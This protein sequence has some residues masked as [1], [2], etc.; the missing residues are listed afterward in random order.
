MGPSNSVPFEQDKQNRQDDTW[1]ERHT[2]QLTQTP[3]LE[4]GCGEGRDSQ[5]LFSHGVDVI[6]AD[7]AA[8]ALKAH[9]TR[10]PNVPRVRLDLGLPLPFAPGTFG[11]VIASLSLHYFSRANTARVFD[12]IRACLRGGGILLLRV[13]STRDVYFG[14]RGHAEIEPNFYRVRTRTKRF[15]EAAD[16]EQLAATGW[17][18]D[19]LEA[20]TIDRY[21][22]P[23]HVWTAVL[24]RLDD[25]DVTA[26][27]G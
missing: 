10:L 26:G 11:T 18:L 2:G 20:A 25:R 21:D 15:F 7:L 24:R 12:A 8:D 22:R 19:L 17:A 23:K 5:W 9:A 1:L 3:R 14:A 16:I 6:A 27:S 4:L 13:N